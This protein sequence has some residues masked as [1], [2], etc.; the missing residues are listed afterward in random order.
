MLTKIRGG[1]NSRRW[2]QCL[3]ISRAYGVRAVLRESGVVPA[4][5][6]PDLLTPFVFPGQRIETLAHVHRPR[7]DSRLGATQTLPTLQCVFSCGVRKTCRVMLYV[8]SNPLALPISNTS[9]PVPQSGVWSCWNEKALD[10]LEFIGLAMTRSGRS[11]IEPWNAERRWCSRC[12]RVF[13]PRPL[14]PVHLHRPGLVTVCA[15]AV[16]PCWSATSAGY[17]PV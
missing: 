6:T 2:P 1:K 4:R 11:R 3:S 16:G 10:P 5:T 12:S 17:R 15:P 8:C 13:R 9:I 7:A 14:N